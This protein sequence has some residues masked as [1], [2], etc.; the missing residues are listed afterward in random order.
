MNLQLKDDKNAS[1]IDDDT[2]FTRFCKIMRFERKEKIK[3]RIQEYFFV[4]STIS[5]KTFR[6]FQWFV[7][8]VLLALV[9]KEMYWKKCSFSPWK[10]Y[11]FSPWKRAGKE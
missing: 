7:A 3:T 5:V 10:K 9:K 4:P 1:E 6:V 2:F 11:S 8:N